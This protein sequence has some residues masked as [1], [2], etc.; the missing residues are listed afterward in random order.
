MVEM[1]NSSLSDQSLESTYLSRADTAPAVLVVIPA[2]N[3]AMHIEA[4]LRQLS[5]G[6]PIGKL[7]RFLICDGGSCDGTQEI[8]ARLAR[9][10]ER[11]VLLHNPKRL[12]SAAVNQ[13][14]RAQGAGFDILVRCDAHSIYPPGFILDL[15]RTM[16][17]TQADAVVVPMDSMGDT[18]LRKAIAWISDTLIGSGG[19]A[20]RGGARSG[21]VD[22]GHHAAFRMATFIGAGGYDESFS[23]NEDAE[24]DCRQRALGARIFLDSAIRIG[25]VPRGTL[26]GLWR[27]YFAYGRGR[28]R[29]VRK[30]PA[31]LRLRQFAVPAHLAI[32]VLCGLSLPW[33]P[34]L[35]VWPGLY[36]A[37]LCLTASVLAVRHGSLCGLLAVPAAVVMHTAFALGFV[38]GM[39]SK[40]E[41]RWCRASVKPLVLSKST[42]G[43]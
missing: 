2:L 16:E 42:D 38:G 41:V 20:H 34:W 40:R 4:V 7:V 32:L 14:V 1:S 43:K 11:L 27:Q 39:V 25:Y 30:H 37:V 15:V 23:H 6:V 35:A 17:R 19:A 24:L 21:Y 36:I 18:C 3:E 22:H 29:T 26:R 8:V 5:S 10:D 31:S 28:S 13:A 9:T 12:Q 33:F